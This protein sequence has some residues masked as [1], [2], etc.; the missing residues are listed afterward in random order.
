MPN[1]SARALQRLRNDPQLMRKITDGGRATLDAQF[2][3][4]SITDAYLKLFASGPN[5]SQHQ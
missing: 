5:A 1:N 4:Q 3:K 2:L